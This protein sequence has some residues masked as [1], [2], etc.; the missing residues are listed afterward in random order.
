MARSASVRKSSD[1]RAQLAQA[2]Q[3]QVPDTSA[4]RQGLNL[5]LARVHRLM[6]QSGLERLDVVGQPFDAELMFAI[7]T[8][9]SST[10]P[11]AH[12]AEQLRPA[13]LWQGK[14]LRTAEVR[15]AK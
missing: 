3:W 9:A 15:L 11:H 8:V 5:I 7:D 4:A 14:L 10:V 6:K 12:V 1:F 13:Y 2:A